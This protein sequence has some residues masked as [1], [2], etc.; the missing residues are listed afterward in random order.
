MLNVISRTFDVMCISPNSN[1]SG[2]CEGAFP[3]TNAWFALAVGALLTGGSL[4]LRGGVSEA[5][6]MNDKV[7]VGCT[8]GVVL[9]V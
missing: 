2:D 3:F 1:R 9:S 4:D 8:A 7:N 6:Q 5:P